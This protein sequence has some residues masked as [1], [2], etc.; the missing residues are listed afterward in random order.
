MKKGRKDISRKL[1]E[2]K[3][4]IFKLFLKLIPQFPRGKGTRKR[5]K[6]QILLV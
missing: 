5:V 4:H 1:K 3:N 2:E 6:D